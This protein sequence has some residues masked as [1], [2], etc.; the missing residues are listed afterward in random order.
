MSRKMI[1]SVVVALLQLA[2]TLSCLIF[3]GLSII[4]ESNPFLINR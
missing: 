4:F 3:V 1:T 2:L